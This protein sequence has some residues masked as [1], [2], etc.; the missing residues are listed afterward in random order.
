[1]RKAKQ[2]WQTRLRQIRTVTTHRPRASVTLPDPNYE[3]ET[4]NYFIGELSCRFNARSPYLR[5][6]INPSGPCENC[7]HYEKSN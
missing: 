5:C 4:R 3:L 7:L 1:M 6:A 2:R